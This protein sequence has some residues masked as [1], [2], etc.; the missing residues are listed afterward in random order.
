LT[1]CH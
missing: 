1:R